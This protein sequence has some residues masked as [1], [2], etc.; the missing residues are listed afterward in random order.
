MKVEANF[1]SKNTVEL[2]V[3]DED[4]SLADI[5]RGELLKEEDVVFAGLKTPHPLL[6]KIIVKVQTKG[7]SPIEAVKKSGERALQRTEEFYEA[8]KQA[9]KERGVVE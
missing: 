3:E 8:A 1:S 2:H 4:Y 6:K 7:S 9:L 5:I